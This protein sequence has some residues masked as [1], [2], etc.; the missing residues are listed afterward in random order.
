MQGLKQKEK[1]GKSD[2]SSSKVKEGHLKRKE[3]DENEQEAEE[4]RQDIGTWYK[5][6]IENN[7]MFFANDSVSSVHKEG[8]EYRFI[9]QKGRDRLKTKRILVAESG[10]MRFI[11]KDFGQLSG[12][13][14]LTTYGAAIVAKESDKDKGKEKEKELKLF[15]VSVFG[16]QPSIIGLESRDLTEQKSAKGIQARNLLGET[17]GT[18]K[19]KQQ[20][21]AI[22]KNQ[23][24]IADLRPISGLIEGSVDEKAAHLPSVETQNTG[25]DQDRPIPP[26]NLE[27]TKPIDIYPFDTL[28]TPGESSEINVKKYMKMGQSE[29]DQLNEE[30]RFPLFVYKHLEVSINASAKNP[31]KIKALIYIMYLFRFR[32]ISKK[33]LSDNE[34]VTEGL[35]DA[36]MVVQDRLLG[37][38]TELA[39][40]GERVMSEKNRDKLTNYILVLALYAEDFVLNTELIIQDLSLPKTKVFDHL[41]ALGCF[42]EKVNESAENS[43]E[44]PKNKD[45]RVARLRAPLQ[46]PRPR[47]P[48]FQN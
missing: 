13:S 47:M 9:Q 19:I 23:V 20:I 18:M 48:Q 37:L 45:V 10:K 3:R 41:K 12:G 31:K 39:E 21:R 36:P 42:V 34:K 32:N 8:L 5:I 43:E 6:K 11:G 14:P 35:Y 28:I 24:D 1:A 44:K 2:G 4:V 40:N 25:P 29:F 22:A 26:Y 38:F 46:F 7:S 16:I 33:S 27:A 30:Q 15:D 17:F